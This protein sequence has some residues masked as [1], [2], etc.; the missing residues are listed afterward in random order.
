MRVEDKEYIYAVNLST[1]DVD[2]INRNPRYWCVMKVNKKTKQYAPVSDIKEKHK[3]K[4][5]VFKKYY[6]MFDIVEFIECRRGF[7]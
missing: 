6:P 7:A 5:L 3:V 1:D 4:K 2:L